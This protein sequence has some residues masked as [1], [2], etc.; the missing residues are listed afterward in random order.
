MKRLVE[1]DAFT[2]IS[3]F[4]DYDHASKTTTIIE[5]QDCTDIVNH[6]KNVAN[7]GGYTK[8]GIKRSWMHLGTI[9]ANLIH[10][11]SI[12]SGLDPYSKEGIRF[13]VKK[14]HERD[15]SHLKV[16]NGKFIR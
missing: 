1:F 4:A 15:Y 7:I 10:K 8:S 11:W 3:T 2:G 6:A 16:A 12:E 14:L 13:I 9:P 5:E